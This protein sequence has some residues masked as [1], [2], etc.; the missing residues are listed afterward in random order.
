MEASK[1]KAAPVRLS[2]SAMNGLGQLGKTFEPI[3]DK[4]IHHA[5]RKTLVN[6]GLAI[7]DASGLK[8]KITAQGSKALKQH[9]RPSR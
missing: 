2:D 3:S 1:S 5:T 7:C 9:S 8:I 4:G 6:N